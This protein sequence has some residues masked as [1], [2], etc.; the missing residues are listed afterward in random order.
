VNGNY[1]VIEGKG[2]S[3][4]RA[5]T[6]FCKANGQVL[7]PLVELIEQARLTVSSVLDQVSQQTIEMILQLSAEQ[8]AGPRTPGKSSG[9]IRWHGRQ[10]GWVSLEEPQLSVER[11]RLRRKGAGR[12]G[13]VEIPA[14]EALRKNPAMGGRMFGAQCGERRVSEPSTFF[15]SVVQRWPHL[16]HWRR[17]LVTKPASRV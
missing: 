11:P 15:S 16:P 12:G 6:A 7:L 4:E 5:L 14:Y 2:K 3:A 8:I 17:L 13:E 9:E 1:H 10:N